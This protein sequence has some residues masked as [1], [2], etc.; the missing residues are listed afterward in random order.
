MF[1][2][3]LRVG[4]PSSQHLGVIIIILGWGWRG[5]IAVIKQ[6]YLSRLDTGDRLGISVAAALDEGSGAARGAFKEAETHDELCTSGCGKTIT[7]YF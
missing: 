5:G 4:S 1:A 6:N 3:T 2:F 7:I